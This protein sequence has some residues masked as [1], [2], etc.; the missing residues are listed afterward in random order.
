MKKVVFL[1]TVLLLAVSLVACSTVKPSAPSSQPGPQGSGTS[2]GGKQEVVVAG[3]GG[4]FEKEFK[5]KVIPEF[6]KKYNA[7]VKYITGV[8]TD[9]LA[10]LQAQKDNPQIDVA[11]MDDGP[12]AQAKV[13]G[14]LDKLDPVQVPNLVNVY[15]MTK[16]KDNVGV[17]IGVVATGLAY[18]KKAF[19]EK[20]WAA[21]ASW[22]DLADP[23]YM[24]K[25][26]LPSI[27]NTYGVHLLVMV[28]R[29]N[30]GGEA[31][32]EPGFAKM[33]EIAKNTITFDK[34]AD[35]SN[36]FLQG[37]AI[38]SAW[39]S[40]RVYTLAAKNFPIAFVFPKEGTPALLP[41]ASPV[42]KAPHPELAQKFINF[43]L[44]EMAQKAI[45]QA[46]FFGPVN[47][48]VKLSPE[49]AAQVVYSDDQIN[50]LT[51]MDWV[52]INAKRA[53]WTERWAKEIE[54]K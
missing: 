30:G 9:T 29:A 1:T 17:A 23:K 36:F 49:L 24:G 50:K 31:N 5:E 4:S 10:K 19:D 44:D 6:E 11:I 15:E 25:M 8:S 21:P 35:V 12:Q 52:S 51:K 22:N 45:A 32:I 46:V 41:M 18:N 7:S 34:T 20:K 2:P 40:G 27:T 43:L 47:K 13:L 33:K 16:D 54:S 14:L 38:I 28:A 42:K 26:V 53:E 37:D 3:Y 48:T 39:G